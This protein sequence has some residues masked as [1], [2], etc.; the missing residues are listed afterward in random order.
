MA[1]PGQT[2][3]PPAGSDIFGQYDTVVAFASSV[4][5]LLAIAAID[6]LTGYELRLQTLY[7]IPVAIATWTA[8]RVWGL[9]LAAA[10][11]GIWLVTFGSSHHYSRSLYFYWDGALWFVTLTIFVLLLARLREELEWSNADFVIVL[12][13][14]GVA[15][16]VADPRKA[17]LLFGNQRFR[18]RFA[19]ESF[20]SLS[21]RR[22]KE[23]WLRWP[24]GRRVVLR[25]LVEPAAPKED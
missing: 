16:Y 25:I 9:A 24:D 12:E 22:A 21:R 3:L 23:C 5:L 2:A 14:I 20:E 7:F 15:A 10:A 4:I 11:L 13:E 8:G 19:V 18:E 6:R 17:E 1:A